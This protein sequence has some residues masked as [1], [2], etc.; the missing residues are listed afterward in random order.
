MSDESSTAPGQGPS[1]DPLVGS[2]IERRYRLDAVVGEGGF[3]TVYRGE[4]LALGV[5]VAIKVLRLPGWVDEEERMSLVAAFMDE[6]RVLTRLRHPHIVSA[7]DLGLVPPRTGRPYLVM[8]WCGGR[9]LKDL[10]AERGALPVAEALAIFAPIVDAMAHAHASGIVHR[11][12]KPANVMMVQGSD[13]RVLPRIIDFGVA[14]LVPAGD[15]AGSGATHTDSGSSPFTPAYAAPEQLARART[16][17]WTDVHALGLLLLSLLTGKH[18]YGHGADAGL[19]A[20]DPV[21]PSPRDHGMDVGSLEAVIER[22]LALKPAARF[23]DAAA[24]R[25]ALARAARGEALAP[26]SPGVSSP[27]VALSLRPMGAPDATGVPSSRTVRGSGRSTRGTR[28]TVVFAALGALLAA[29]AGAVVLRARGNIGA[30]VTSAA[31]AGATGAPTPCDLDAQVLSARFESAGLAVLSSMRNT[32]FGRHT[33]GVTVRGPDGDLALSIWDADGTLDGDLERRRREIAERVQAAYPDAQGRGSVYGASGACIAVLSGSDRA[34]T[35]ALFDE[36]L[37]DRP[38]EVRGS[39]FAGDVAPVASASAPARR[40]TRLAELSG[41]ELVERVRATGETVT[42]AQRADSLSYAVLYDGHATA[43]VYFYPTGGVAQ[44]EA[45]RRDTAAP[46][47]CV[48]A[49]DGGALAVLR[50]D[51]RLSDPRFFAK[52]FAGLGVT[53]SVIPR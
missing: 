48:F 32:S 25:D 45:L 35:Q 46:G 9:S 49:Q 1:T 24:L 19:A 29:V 53:P 5:P 23:P 31:P 12:L 50:G 38:L 41:D 15:T 44:L 22:A 8:E 34:R 42:Y 21:R 18:P 40:A 47:T 37:R 10:L 2:V 30:P 33:T 27:P 13:G 52:V 51:G 11:D 14:K 16:G 6:A 4:H 17:P 3:G 26:A 43:T 7:L 36:V 20:V 28:G 39:T